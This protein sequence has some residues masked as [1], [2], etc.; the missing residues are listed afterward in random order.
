M[1][2]SGGGDYFK[3]APSRSDLL[4]IANYITYLLNAIAHND[5]VHDL[6]PTLAGTGD[7]VVANQR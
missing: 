5:I 1:G 4:E 3:L 7:T 6:L 2:D